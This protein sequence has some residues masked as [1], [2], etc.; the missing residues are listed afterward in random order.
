MPS[1]GGIP[2]IKI[3]GRLA[4]NLIGLSE[5]AVLRSR[6]FSRSAISEGTP[7]R[8]PLSTSAFFTHSLSVC[9]VQPIFAARAVRLVFDHE[10]EH[11]SRWAAVSSIAGEPYQ[12]G[13]KRQEENAEP[14][15][16]VACLN[17][18]PQKIKD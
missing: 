4:Q 3:R 5:F 10:K 18:I 14:E 1:G 7:A 8:T 6:A 9:A 12:K 15:V 2:A 11:R 13:G 16:H 17:T